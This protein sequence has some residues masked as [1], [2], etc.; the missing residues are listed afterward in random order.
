LRTYNVHFKPPIEWPVIGDIK[1]VVPKAHLNSKN[2][3]FASIQVYNGSFSHLDTINLDENKERLAFASA[4]R[5]T[6]AVPDEDAVQG[7]VNDA[8]RNLAAA[9]SDRLLESASHQTRAA[10]TIAAPS[11]RFVSDERGL[12]YVS[13]D[14]ESGLELDPVWLSSAIEVAAHTRDEQGENWGRLLEVL[15]PEGNEHRWA[16][17]MRM[18]A[19]DGREYLGV[20]L[21]LGL[22]IAPSK[23]ARGLLTYFIQSAPN[24][25]LAR[26]VDRVGWYGNAFVLPNEVI[27]DTAGEMVVWQHEHE[28]RRALRSYAVR[29]TIEAWRTEVAA[30]CARNPILLFSVSVAFAGPLLW[31]TGD[32]NGGFHLRGE[33][34]KGK[35]TAGFVA[36]SVYGSKKFVNSWRATSNGLEGVAVRHNDSLLV[37]DELKQVSPDEAGEVAYMLANGMGKQRSDRTGSARERYE[38]RLL[39]LSNGEISL[40]DHMR[41]AGRRVYA[42]QEVRLLDIPAVIERYGAFSELHGATDGADFSRQLTAAAQAQHG[43]P[44]RAYLKALLT[45]DKTID[46]LRARIASSRSAFVN[47]FLPP[48]SD[49]QV[50]RAAYRFGLVAVAGELATKLGITGWEE[51]EATM[52]AADCFERWLHS[53]GGP[54]QLE[55]LQAFRQVRTFIEA[56]GEDRFTPWAGPD[57][58]P[59]ESSSRTYDRVGFRR[60]RNDQSEYYILPESFRAVVCKGLDYH[61]AVKALRNRGWLV[62][63]KHDNPSKVERL[64][65][66]GVTRCYKIIPREV[67]DDGPNTEDQD[68]Q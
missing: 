49:G 36:A 10:E 28:V 59:D 66:L 30:R 25:Q 3:A 57:L 39:L 56:H 17:P 26:C 11:G 54:I 48:G 15:D 37:L 13:L 64:P 31:I 19:G 45:S 24:I 35:S 65:G 68:E 14:P 5:K 21:D 1:L 33:S 9:V 50:Y 2:E 62:P 67:R 22:I 7:A 20:L 34:S 38:F 53:R 46:D 44:I 12:H 43:T 29:G 8:L 42:G 23:G 18:L 32:E 60:D 40:A 16:M 41:E 27:G 63:D 6:G 4:L 55:E 61:V 47:G 58:P 52:A 51:G